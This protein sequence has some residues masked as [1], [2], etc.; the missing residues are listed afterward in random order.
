MR[1]GSTSLS[2]SST[3]VCHST[4]CTTR[5]DHGLDAKCS[6]ARQIYVKAVDQTNHRSLVNNAIAFRCF[7]TEP[8]SLP[9]SVTQQRWGFGCQHRPHTHPLQRTEGV[10]DDGI[11]SCNSAGAG[12]H[13]GYGSGA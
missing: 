5:V 13:G 2:A 11:I 6:E 10:G 8:P 12:A 3:V 7:L 4:L 1:F 9:V